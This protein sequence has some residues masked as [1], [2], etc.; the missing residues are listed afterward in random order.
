M[1]IHL[2]GPDAYQRSQKERQIVATYEKKYGHAP[3][4][5]VLSEKNDY[6]RLL[7]FLESQSLFSPKG[8]AIVSEVEPE[9]AKLIKTLVANESKTLL[10]IAEKKLSKEFAFLL[11]DPVQSQEFPE[12]KGTELS[13]FIRKEA[14][15]QNVEVSDAQVASLALLCGS[16]TWGIVHELEKLS[17]GGATPNGEAGKDF[18]P[19]IQGFMRGTLGSRLS[20]LEWLLQNND[21]VAIF[22]VSTSLA[23]PIQK[24]RMANYDVAIKSGKLEYEE[25][26]LDLILRD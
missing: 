5:F 22:N 6:A 17:L 13:S 7:S 24:I 8:F 1:L 21:P 16:D 14:K 12:L 25:A 15:K 18:F 2:Y 23:T 20:S 19:L 4:R 11:K 10:I 9:N 26:L 3:E